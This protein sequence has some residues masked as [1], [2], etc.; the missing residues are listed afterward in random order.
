[1]NSGARWRRKAAGESAVENK[2]ALNIPYWVDHPMTADVDAE[3]SNRIGQPVQHS[4][5]SP[6]GS[7]FIDSTSP[8]PTRAAA[9]RCFHWMV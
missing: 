5:R 4:S 3:L 1:L 8:Q 6:Q 7:S 9:H 2:D